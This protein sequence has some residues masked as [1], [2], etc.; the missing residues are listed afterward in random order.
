MQVAGL[1]VEG[2]EGGCARRCKRQ[3]AAALLQLQL[4]EQQRGLVQLKVCKALRIFALLSII[5]RMS[6]AVLVCQ[7]RLVAAKIMFF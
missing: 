5:L 6:P 4:Q 2:G 3:H 7:L 1:V